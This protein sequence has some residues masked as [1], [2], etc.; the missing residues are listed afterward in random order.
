MVW[1]FI[2]GAVTCILDL[3]SMTR[4]LDPASFKLKYNLSSVSNFARSPCISLR[5]KV[6]LGCKSPLT[7]SLKDKGLPFAVKSP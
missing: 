4:T 3:W 6:E 5:S 7:P 2:N 1:Q